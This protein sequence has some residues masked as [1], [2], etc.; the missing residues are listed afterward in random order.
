MK[1]EDL[2]EGDFVCLDNRERFSK[3]K[4]TGTTKTQ[5][6]VGTLKYRKDDGGLVG[7]DRWSQSRITPWTDKHQAKLNEALR[8]KKVK[9]LL[10][11][12]SQLDPESINEENIKVLTDVFNKS[13]LS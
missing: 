12:V 3:E 5:V 7:G 4:V 10:Y 11:S 2:S 1:L 9:S 6:K 8:I 13:K